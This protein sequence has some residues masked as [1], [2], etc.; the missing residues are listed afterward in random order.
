MFKSI[1]LVNFRKHDDR[2]IVFTAGTNVIRGVNEQGKS[3]IFEA[4]LYAMF[5]SSA[6]KETIADVVTYGLKES[7]LKV[8]LVLEISGVEYTITRG[9]SGAEIVYAD[10]TV[11]GQSATKVFMENLLGSAMQVSQQLMFAKQSAI[12]GVLTENGA[13]NGLVEK[14]ANLGK[15]E[16]LVDTIQNRLPNGNLNAIDQQVVTLQSMQLETP[17]KPSESETAALESEILQLQEK[18]D[19]SKASALDEREVSKALARVE[20]ARS[21]KAVLVAFNQQKADLTAKVEIKLPELLCTPSDLETLRAESANESLE[22]ARLASY[23]KVFPKAE[24]TVAKTYDQLLLDIEESSVQLASEV[25]ALNKAEQVRALKLVKRINEKAC[26][27]CKKDL[28]DVP[29]VAS[30]NA[31]IDSEVIEQDMLIETSKAKIIVKKATLAEL[32]TLKTLSDSIFKLMDD[33]W[34]Y[35]DAT[36]PPKPVWLGPVPKVGDSSARLKEMEASLTKYQKALAVKEAAQEALA[37]L[38]EPVVEDV[39][40]AIELLSKHED[41]QKVAS[42]MFSELQVLSHQLNSAKKS[43]AHNMKQYE[44]ALENKEKTAKALEETIA[45]RK[46]MVENNELIKK[47]RSIRPKIAAK[48]W[49]TVQGAISHYFSAIRQTDSVVERTDTGFTVNGRSIKGLS[50]STEDALGLAIRMALSKLFIPWVSVLLLDESFSACDE[51]RELAGISTLVGA[52]FEQII[53]VTHSDA[54]ESMADN[55]IVL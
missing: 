15:I 23:N 40:D 21:A 10:Q 51:N 19:L 52:G 50:G 13:A 41:E 2:Y 55:L 22:K 38:K 39:S 47:L 1:R 8:I 4:M 35:D 11:T 29:E 53:L 16:E 54:P 3:S 20:A 33:N 24:E 12:K 18:I 28:S 34:G 27:F 26:A 45:T 36:L 42:S 17:E 25:D 32:K 49:G 30:I 48:M 6:L 43:F 44:M 14:L 9:T 37:S 46:V 7:Q 5:G 31:S